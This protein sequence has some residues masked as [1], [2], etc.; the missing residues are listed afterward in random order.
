MTVLVVDDL[1]Q[2]VFP[3]RYARDAETA[4]SILE[5]AQ[6]RGECFEALWLDH[7]LGLTGTIRPVLAWLEQAHHD[8]CLPGIGEIVICTASPV[9]RDLIAVVADRLGISARIVDATDYL[10]YDA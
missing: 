7:D 3:A 1:R 2:F 9:G 5:V 10:N 4:I 6:E 8:R